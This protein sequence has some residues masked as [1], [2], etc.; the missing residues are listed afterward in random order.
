MKGENEM[1]SNTRDLPPV[2]LYE[3]PARWIAERA[4]ASRRFDIFDDAQARMYV[5]AIDC[6]FA[7]WNEPAYHSAVQAQELSRLIAGITR[8]TYEDL[9]CVTRY[10]RA[11]VRAFTSR[12]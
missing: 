6:G 12:H 11:T 4:A 8:D 5:A 9:S 2:P 7:E 3:P 1:S 10:I